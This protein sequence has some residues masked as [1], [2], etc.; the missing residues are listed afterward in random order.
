MSVSESLAAPVILVCKNNGTWR[1]CLDYE[2]LNLLTIK[3]SHPLPR[4]DNALDAFS[5]SAWYFTMDLKHD[6]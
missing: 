4:V 5:Y 6:Y 3:D 2:K 1:F